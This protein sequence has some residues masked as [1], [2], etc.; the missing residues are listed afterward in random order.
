M[1]GE[2]NPALGID[3]HATG[4]RHAAHQERRREPMPD[5]QMEVGRAP[6]DATD[7]DAQQG[8]NGLLREHADD[9]AQ[10]RQYRDRQAH[11]GRR[12]MRGIAQR[13]IIRR[14]ATIEEGILDEA[15]RIGDREHATEDRG[16][17]QQRPQQQWPVGQALRMQGFGEEH[18]LAHEA[19]QQ[20]HPRHGCG[21]DH[22]QPAGDRQIG[23]EAAQ[24]AQVAATGLAIDDAGGHEQRRLEHGMVDQ[25]EEAGDGPERGAEPEQ[26]GDQ[27]QVADRRVGQQPF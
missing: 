16:H 14:I 21:G 2:Q 1:G 9:H 13:G 20:G 22:R 5:R 24:A 19:V 11:P 8:R 6:E 12:L 7:T 15:Q 26:E 3:Q 27:P 23:I 10:D 18:L 4:E 25:V 17:R